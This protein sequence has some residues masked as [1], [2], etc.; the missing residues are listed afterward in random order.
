MPPNLNY[1]KVDNG[2][3]KLRTLGKINDFLL[4]IFIIYG[5][6]MAILMGIFSLIW[7][8]DPTIFMPILLTFFIIGAL[9][10]ITEAYLKI[11]NVKKDLEINKDIYDLTPRELSKRIPKP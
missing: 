3:M 8:V 9:F 5:F 4:R 7:K 6:V 10:L 11:K 1:F 2:L